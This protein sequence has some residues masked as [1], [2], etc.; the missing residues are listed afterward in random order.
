MK[1]ELKPFPFCG[2]E[3]IKLQDDT[4]NLYGFDGYKLF[5]VRCRCCLFSESPREYYWKNGKYCTPK[6]ERAKNNALAKLYETWNRRANNEQA[7]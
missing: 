1:P 2:G 4:E 6:T 7:D 5:C 3:D